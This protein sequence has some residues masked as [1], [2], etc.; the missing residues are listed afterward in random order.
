[1]NDERHECPDHGRTHTYNVMSKA[2]KMFADFHGAASVPV[3]VMWMGTDFEGHVRELP[4]DTIERAV[5]S[6]R[7]ATDGLE[8]WNED[9]KVAAM[10]AAEREQAEAEFAMRLGDSAEDDE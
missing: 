1:M 3:F 9:R 7:R 6:L 5:K 4:I 10:E 8:L 2:D